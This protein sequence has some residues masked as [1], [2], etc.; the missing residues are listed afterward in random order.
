M[1]AS[2]R[3]AMANADTTERLR[4]QT[5]ALEQQLRGQR[6]LLQITESILTTLDARGVL[7]SIT[8]RLGRLIVCDNVAIEV[9]DPSSGLL[10]PLTARGI[11][12]A[13]YLEPWEPGETGVATWVVEHNEPVFITD[14]RND[15]R[16][17]HFR[18]DAGVARWQPDRRPA[19]RPWRR[20]R[21]PHDR[22]PRRRQHLLGRGVRARPAL[23]GAGLDRA[24]ER[25]GL[26]GGRDPGAD[27][28]PHRPVQ[29]RHVPGVARAERPRRHAVRPDHARPRRLPERQQRARPPG[30]RHAAAPDRRRASSGPVAT[31]TSSS[32]TAATSSRSCCPTPTRPAR[33][34]SPSG[35]ASPWPR[36]TGRVTASVG[37]ATF[38]KDGRTAT[39]VLLA[40][41]RACYVAK[42]GGRDRIVTAAEGL[43]LAAELSLQPPTPVDSATPRPARPDRRHRV[44]RSMRHHGRNAHRADLR[45]GSCSSPC[46]WWRASR[47]RPTASSPDQPVADRHARRSR[48]RPARPRHRPSSARPRR[49]SRRSSSTRS[50]RATTSARSP[51][52]SRRRSGASP[53]GTA[54]PIRRSTRTRAPTEPNYL[55]IGWVLAPHPERRGRPGEPADPAARRQTP[56]PAGPPD[57][58]R[59]IVC[60]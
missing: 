8:D 49:R 7:E 22:A 42:R 27:R 26:P 31:R 5:L 38:P 3:Q 60:R 28:R 41:D 37:V 4:E 32:A 16:V 47:N 10:T 21:R 56:E 19:A 35:R 15:P 36:P 17:N 14:E 30:R 20:D 55:M 1:P 48:R 59:A 13:Y 23:R 24:P 29:P 39:D 43:A 40:A 34:R 53:T 33:S 44:S 6:E 52:G 11:H 58:R 12:A 25:R 50:S 46:S 9:V 2:P 57:R 51:S 45:W 18:E 54:P